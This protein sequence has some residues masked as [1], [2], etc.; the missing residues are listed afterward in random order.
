MWKL[1]SMAHENITLVSSLNS[2]IDIRKHSHTLHQGGLI[3]YYSLRTITF[4]P[5][6][7]IIRLT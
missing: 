2:I 4:I 7:Q 3:F 1:V 5:L 6:Q